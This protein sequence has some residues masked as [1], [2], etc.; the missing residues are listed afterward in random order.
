[1]YSH[2]SS[3]RAGVGKRG[4]DGR[5]YRPPRKPRDRKHT[6]QPPPLKQC[7]CLVELHLEEYREPQPERHHACFG[8]GRS[9][10]E[11][12]E[13]TVRT[14]YG[15]HLMVPGKKQTGP[16]NLVA[17]TVREVLPALAWLVERLHVPEDIPVRFHRNVKDYQDQVLEG[18]IPIHSIGAPGTTSPYWLFQSPSWS[19]LA[20]NLMVS[21]AHHGTNDDLDPCRDP[22]MVPS[23][24]LHNCRATML[25]TCWDNLKFKLGNDIVGKLDI[26]VDPN[27][28]YAFAVG[29]P[30]PAA[31]LSM[32][33][34]AAFDYSDQGVDQTRML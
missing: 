18:I 14:D 25:Q 9:S 28:E 4:H 20:C 7:D 3:A 16:V 24:S 15:C 12:C 22:S 13:R 19:V 8:G 2:G 32:E 6:M 27:V 23:S 33:I 10:L 30:D 34:A 1:M 17:R 26:I 5:P 31:R 11:Q 29:D 21:V